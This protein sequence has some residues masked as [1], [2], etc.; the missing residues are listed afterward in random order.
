MTILA[1]IVGA[2]LG[3]FG[4]F[5]EEIGKGIKG[6]LNAGGQ[7]ALLAGVVFT[8]YS[9]NDLWK[10]H[11]KNQL[12][13]VHFL[14]KSLRNE[15]PKVRT[16]TAK[17][18]GE[19]QAPEAVEPLI[20]ALQDSEP[21]VRVAMAEALG[22]LQD[23][24]AVKP[25]ITAL[26]DSNPTVKAAMAEALGKLQD[27]RAVEPLITALQD[28]KPSVRLTVAKVLGE[29]HDSRAVEPLITAL[30]DPEDVVRFAAAG[31][32][33]QLNDPRAIEPLIVAASDKGFPRHNAVIALGE[34]GFQLEDR[35]MQTR[36]AAWL[37]SYANTEDAFDT[38]RAAI[39]AAEKIGVPNNIPDDV[40][41]AV[42]VDRLV[43][44]YR[45]HPQGFVAGEGDKQEN[46]IRRIGNSLN[47][48]GGME[49]M[50]AAHKEFAR[51]CGVLGA[52]RNLEFLWNRIGEWKG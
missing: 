27:S 42:A 44:I 34:I 18:L 15:D 16:D 36:I 37:Q 50:L 3:G 19:M 52:P 28:H 32:L 40:W 51:K 10:E 9:I 48:R 6:A 47:Q 30:Q 21:I 43:G 8:I 35:T 12:G 1:G 13:N 20:T 39:T 14:I 49:L 31:A 22:K 4:V 25:L 23:S 7:C 11:K 26:Q 29:L 5:G 38:H 2:V 33:G 45:Q 41:F 46:E 24:R 17:V